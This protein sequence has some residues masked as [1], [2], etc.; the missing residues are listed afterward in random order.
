MS[1]SNIADRMATANEKKPEEDTPRKKAP[2]APLE[3]LP[4]EIISLILATVTID[5]NEPYVVS[6]STL[7]TPATRME[8]DASA[9]RD[10]TSLCRVS[11]RMVSKARPAL[12][13]NILIDNV[14][15]LVL[16]CWT[17]LKKPQLGIFV[18]RLSLNIRPGGKY[19]VD[20]GQSLR[21]ID[22]TPLLEFAHHGFTEHLTVDHG[23]GPTRTYEIHLGRLYT[24]QLRVLGFTKHLESL[25]I[26]LHHQP[27][28]S[29]VDTERVD[30]EVARGVLRPLWKETSPS[31]S[32]LRELQLIGKEKYCARWGH[33]WRF[34]AL[35]CRSFLNLPNLEQ[36][37][38]FNH[39]HGWFD[40]SRRIAS[41]KHLL[42]C[43]LASQSLE[44][45]T[46]TLLMLF[47]HTFQG[48]SGSYVP[49]PNL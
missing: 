16:L 3:T 35:V 2:P 30:L 43:C 28:L 32:R 12:Y 26:N 27:D 47:P 13:R 37:V 48:R 36:L 17:F 6:R 19:S 45:F 46:D 38:W 14:D 8:Q 34:A 11:R 1:L 41:G 7:Q 20:K 21:C 10:L 15:T 5:V 44:L 22:I 24:L 31:L 49:T 42:P 18:K 39:A 9:R 4:R 23:S 29:F 25:D 40:F 33:R